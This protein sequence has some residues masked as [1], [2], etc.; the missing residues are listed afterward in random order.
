[1]SPEQ[2]WFDLFRPRPCKR[3]LRRRSCGNHTLLHHVLKNGHHEQRISPGVSVDQGWQ[4]PPGKPRHRRTASAMYSATSDRF[5]SFEARFRGLE[6][7]STRS[8]FKR[9]QRTLRNDDVCGTIGSQQQQ[10]RRPTTARQRGNEIE[11]GWINPVKVFEDQHERHLARS[12]FRVLRRFHA[13]FVR[14]WLQGSPSAAR[15]AGRPSP[16]RGTESARWGPVSPECVHHRA[17]VLPA[18]PLAERFQHRVVSLLSSEPFDA[19]P[20]SDPQ[21][22]YGRGALRERDRPEWFSRCPLPR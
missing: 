16:A 2:L 22:G 6:L 10:L 20:A 14:A 15:F 3:P 8:C 13:P 1:M 4:I 11:S 18:Q 21:V 19:L 5:K 7:W 12:M 17:I 9:F